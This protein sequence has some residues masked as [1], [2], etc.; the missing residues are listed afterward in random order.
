[1]KTCART[2]LW[3]VYVALSDL[4]AARLCRSECLSVFRGAET[5]GDAT[6]L[7]TSAEVSVLHEVC[8]FEPLCFAALSFG[9]SLRRCDAPG[10]RSQTRRVRRVAVHPHV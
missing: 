5:P 1:M 7:G 9:L 4:S 2:H 8:A 3:R 6:H 10:M